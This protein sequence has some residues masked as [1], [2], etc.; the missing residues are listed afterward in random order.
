[1]GLVAEHPIVFRKLE[2]WVWVVNLYLV[3]KTVPCRIRH[4]VSVGGN[5]YGPVYPNCGACAIMRS[6]ED[7]ER[8]TK[9][10]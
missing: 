3:H 6:D 5:H 4:I 2:R 8:M 7:E 10:H 1:L 9:Y